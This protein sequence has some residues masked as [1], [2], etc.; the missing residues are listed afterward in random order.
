MKSCKLFRLFPI[1]FQVYSATIPTRDEV[2]RENYFRRNDQL[3]TQ[4]FSAYAHIPYRGI[5]DPFYLDERKLILHA[6]GQWHDV[7]GEKNSI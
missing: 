7:S 1:W 2:R 6:L 5:G 4:G 3:T